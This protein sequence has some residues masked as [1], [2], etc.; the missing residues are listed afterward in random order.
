MYFSLLF[1]TGLF[2]GLYFV[3]VIVKGTAGRQQSLIPVHGT[4]TQQL[5]TLHPPEV[6]A[7]AALRGQQQHSC[8]DLSASDI[9]ASGTFGRPAETSCP[10]SSSS[11]AVPPLLRRQPSIF[12][13]CYSSESNAL[14]SL[15]FS[16]SSTAQS[17][18]A[19]ASST[20]SAGGALV[21]ASAAASSSAALTSSSQ[22]SLPVDAA[23]ALVDC[24]PPYYWEAKHMPRLVKVSPN[25]LLSKLY[26]SLRVDQVNPL[27]ARIRPGSSSGI[28]LT[29][30]FLISSVDDGSLN[31]A[32]AAE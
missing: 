23:D 16:S 9:V 15:L 19:G 5:D 31:G 6:D 30:G 2:I 29:G 27:S 3:F 10:S 24:L 12:R 28:P 26:T 7:A 13:R 22:P 25:F 11:S 14:I 17:S 4:G 18:G 20:P 32:G 8:D 1:S 21:P